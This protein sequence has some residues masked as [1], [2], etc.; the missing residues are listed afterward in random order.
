MSASRL[1]AVFS[2]EL[3]TS[4]RRP[5]VWFLIALLFLLS[6]G[7]SSGSVHIQSGDASVGG[8]KA[9]ITSEFNFAF[10]I[11]II[12]MLLYAF[13]TA[14]ACGMAI[15]QDDDL[16]VGE[17]LHA[18]PLS[19]RD[20][21]WGKFLGVTTAL[22]VVLGL[23]L[24]FAV[25]FNHVVPNAVA[26]EVRGPFLLLNYLRPALVF[27]LPTLLFFAGIAFYLG[28]R[29]RQPI[30]VFLFP[31]GALLVCTFFL[32][33]WSPTWLDPRLN[34]A[35]M[36]L[37]PS[38][39]R[40][41]Q[42]TWLKIDHGAKFYNTSRI[43]LDAGFLLSRVTFAG[44]GLAGVALAGRHLAA[45]LRGERGRMGARRA[46]PM[47]AAQVRAQDTEDE[48]RPLAEL[49]MHTKAL[50]LFDGCLT[51]ARTELRNLLTHPGIYLFAALILL[52]TLL[53]STV[54]V[55][56]FETRL[57]LTPGLM[58]VGTV[59]ALTLMICLLLLFYTVESL[60]RDRTSR[61]A[62]ITYSTPVHTAANLLGRTLANS[63]IGLLLIAATFLGCAIALLIQGKVPLDFR[64]FLLVW[65]ALLLPT[66]IGWTAFVAAVQAVSGQRFFTYGFCLGILGLTGYLRV[67]HHMSWVGNWML[68]DALQW[69]DMGTFE[70]DRRALLLNR[71]LVLGLA[72]LLTAIAV[73]A[74]GRREADAISTAVRL[75]PRSLGRQA[76]RFSWLAAVPAVAGIM[77]WLAVM[78][79]FQ[80]DAAKK[81]A[82]DYWRQNLATWKDAPQPTLAAA[83]VDLTLEP[84]R[85]W[86]HSKG[87]YDLLND[88]DRELARFAVS[89]GQHWR[90]VRWTLAGRSY[91]P[92]NRSGLYV[93]V[94]PTPLPRGGHLTI[95]FEFEGIFPQGITSNGGGTGEF[96]LPS[97]V[98]LTSFSPSFVPFIGYRE[99]VGV[100]EDNRYEPK[101]YPPDFYKGQ[102]DA[103]A[104]Y[105]IPFKTRVRISAPA[106]YT[107]NSVGTLVSEKV[108]GGRR[109]VVWQ[110]DYPVH[111]WN[112]VAGRWRV[113][114]GAGT[115]IFYH[116]THTANIG[117][118]IA[119]LDAARRYYSQWFC[120][121][122]WHELKISEFPALAG[123]AQGFPTNISFSEGIGFLTESGARSDLVFMVTAHETAH[124]WWG[125]IL[126]PG[127]G[128]GGDILSEGMAHFS[129]LLLFEGVKGTGA[130]IEFAKR[131]E[132]RYND[133]RR[134][135]AEHPLVEIDDSRAG[136]ETVKYDKGGWVFW[137]LM[138]QLGRERDLA[139][140][141]RFLADWR[142][143]SDHAVLQDFIAAMRP[144][145]R[146]AAAY[147]AFV[148]QWFFQVVL[149]E[150][151]LGE[152]HRDRLPGGP[153]DHGDRW[154]ATVRVKNTGTGRMPVEIAAVRGERFD[155]AGRPKSGYQEA[156]TTVVL[157]PGES[158]AVRL[159]CSF[160]PERV[161]VDPDALVLQLRRKAAVVK[162]PGA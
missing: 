11:A 111:F 20:Y 68:W 72:A 105:N 117:S 38:G 94:P 161:V 81:K 119:T 98:V 137:M 30:L 66:F 78:D 148:Q 141:K 50:Q 143:S 162:L 54:A 106:A 85:R 151:Q 41:L 128:P 82:R 17:I 140:L 58:A 34:R 157:G 69:S 123:Y 107:L 25:F 74:F 110:S 36:L 29:L 53:N 92:E 121:Y 63:A 89:G 12:S 70:I 8:T 132:E 19:P 90:K 10:L 91:K 134:P 84:D 39:F 113:R 109:T 35:L 46:A 112:V 15:V 159:L 60:E 33:D 14:I 5:L 103:Q 18:T 9:W 16:K 13:F 87:T 73:R 142:S 4:L 71:L 24:S 64:P 129:T 131:I 154:S 55:G 47:A 67:T 125:N 37:D 160:S 122:P 51:I 108:L 48:P 156:R 27:A 1:R 133:R 6:W 96:I 31:L 3:S 135:D 42:E 114:R 144:F 32:W 100:E 120:P 118:M 152:P 124:Q 88:R 49:G 104:G 28:E 130:R 65:G 86:L 76:L 52:Q 43:G 153:G 62:P 75:R 97:G 79:G 101:V 155:D 150:Y 146:D 138:Q 145:A 21:V 7:F 77:L 80:G 83:D 127:Q 57:L 93:F 136:D 149:P 102:T 115:A 2:L 95:G 116:P 40:W 23:H 99:D 126:T 59:N 44:I 139:G 61:V 26:A 56:A 22:L 147:D 158:R 45:H